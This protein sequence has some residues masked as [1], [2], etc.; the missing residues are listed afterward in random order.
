MDAYRFLDLYAGGETFDLIFADPPYAKNAGDPDHASDLAGSE[1]LVAALSPGDSRREF[2]LACETAMLGFGDYIS[3]IA[4]AC[5]ANAA[6]KPGESAHWT[7]MAGVCAHLASEPPR[8][9]HEALQ[10]MQ[11]VL[12][13]V[14]VG[15]DHSQTSLGRMDQTLYPFYRRDVEAGTITSQKAFEL[16]CDA[17]IQNNR[18]QPA[19]GAIAVIVSGSDAEGNDLTHPLT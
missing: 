15:E 19:G 11:F 10:L 14:W 5:E 4:A 12:F 6:A 8:T 18:F 3:R 16:I 7:K 9:F 1:K 13:G 2:Y 17:Y